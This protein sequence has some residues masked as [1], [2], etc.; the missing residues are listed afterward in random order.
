MAGLCGEERRSFQR[1]KAAPTWTQ[2]P[3]CYRKEKV[4]RCEHLIRALETRP[5]PKIVSLSAPNV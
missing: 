1:E 3:Q 4:F 2:V 5:L